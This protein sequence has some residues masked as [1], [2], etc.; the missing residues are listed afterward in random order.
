MGSLWLIVY[1][2]IGGG[3]WYYM[4]H[5]TKQQRYEVFVAA[6]GIVLVLG[7]IGMIYEFIAY[8]HIGVPA[9]PD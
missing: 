7:A 4:S 9:T 6:V 5:T 8:G 1:A 2:L 3:F